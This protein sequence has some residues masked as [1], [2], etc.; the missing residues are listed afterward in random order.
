[1]TPPTWYWSHDIGPDQV[2]SVAGSGTR[3]IRLSSYGSGHRQRFA[4]LMYMEPNAERTYLLNLEAAELDSQLRQAQAR[5]VAITVDASGLQPRFSVVLDAAAGPRS[6]VHLDRAEAEVRALL[7]DEHGIAD[8]ATYLVA[9]ERRYAV[10][11]EARPGPSWLFTEVTARRLR[12][13]LFRLGVTLVRLR[14]NLGSE[15]QEFTA[16]A[17]R[18]SGVGTTWYANLDGDSVAGRLERH[19]AYPTDLDAVRDERGVRFT[20]IMRR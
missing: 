16:V 6:T 5:P 14:A 7:D 13:R 8:I 20:V 18:S 4:A 9:G 19:R 17:E 15:R 2:E 1:M 3:L 11:L 12:F 10:V